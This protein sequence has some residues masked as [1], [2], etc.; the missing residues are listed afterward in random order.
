[1]LAIARYLFFRAVESE[2]SVRFTE[3]DSERKPDVTKT[4]NTNDTHFTVPA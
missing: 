2:R 3:L 4:D 1:M